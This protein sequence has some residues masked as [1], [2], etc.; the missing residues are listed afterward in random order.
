MSAFHLIANPPRTPDLPCFRTA[1]GVLEKI[2]NLKKRRSEGVT[3]QLKEGTPATLH[4]ICC[5]NSLSENKRAKKKRRLEK[6]LQ[7]DPLDPELPV[8][9]G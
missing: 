9:K 4:R 7:T 6:I 5:A 8:I 3:D 2:E 1:V